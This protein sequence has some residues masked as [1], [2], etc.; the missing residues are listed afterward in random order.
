MHVLLGNGKKGWIMKSKKREREKTYGR[1]DEY[2]YN[3][4]SLESLS[5]IYK[6]Q[7]LAFI[8]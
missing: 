5:F 8:Y 4:C 7:L 2:N 6:L 3:E 1:N